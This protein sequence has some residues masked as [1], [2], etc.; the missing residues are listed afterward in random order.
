MTNSLSASL[1]VPL[2]DQYTKNL[3]LGAIK[4]KEKNSHYIPQC[5]ADSNITIISY[6]DLNIM[7]MS[8]CGASDH[9]YCHNST[10]ASLFNF[11]TV[12]SIIKNLQIHCHAAKKILQPSSLFGVM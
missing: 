1:L 5:Y 12:G 10:Q 4:K 6:R 9:C 2:W 8:H 7:M 3:T 11:E